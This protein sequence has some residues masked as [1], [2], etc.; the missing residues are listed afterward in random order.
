MSFLSKIIERAIL[1]Q[2]L[3]LLERNG[4]IPLVQSA[5]RKHHSTETALIKIH[6][7]MAE[8]NCRGMSSLLVLLDLSAAFDTVD[9]ELLL[10]DL[11]S[12]GIRD[13]ALLLLKS[14]LSDRSQRVTINRATSESVPLQFGVPQGSVLGPILFLVYTSSLASLLDA[15]DVGYHFYAD[16]TQLYVKMTN[17]N[18]AK[19]RV[20]SV[21]SDIKTWMERRK[22]KL[23]DS[24]TEIIIIRGNRRVNEHALTIDV[25]ESQLCPVRTVKN[26]G[27]YFNP[28]LNYKEHLGQVVRSCNLHIRNLYSLKLFLNRRCLL[29]LVHTMVFSRIDYCNGLWIGL[30]NYLLKQVQSVLNR[31]ARLVFGLPPRT[32][33]T[34]SLIELHW[35]PV[36]ARIEFKLCLMTFKVLKYG[37]PRYL[38]EMLKR[39]AA[40]PGAILRSEDDHLRLEEP[41][42][43]EQ[44][45]FSDRS[46]SYVAPRLYNRLPLSVRQLTSVDSFKKQ[47]KTFLFLRSYDLGRGVMTDDYRV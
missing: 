34:S 19:T 2:L 41:V 42:A 40:H 30:P 10:K 47:L 31:A 23:N 25:G 6:N 7:D 24:K 9:H 14:Y 46:F 18:E 27:V 33:T 32:P 38:A 45:S 36:K 43:V 37:Q 39:P 20:E 28:K 4:V 35:L 44:S 29:T 16:D 5:Y 22:L 15:H 17:I 3:P 11:H 8:N 26:L 21:I 13:N 1:D 12:C